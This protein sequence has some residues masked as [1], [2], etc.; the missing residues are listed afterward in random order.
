MA[1][2][3]EPIYSGGVAQLSYL[4]G[5]DSEGVGAVIDPRPDCEV[6][7]QLARAKGMAI[8]GIFETHIHAD[9][10]SGAR[11][12]AKRLGGAVPVR[13]SGEGGAAYGFGVVKLADGD[14]FHFGEMRLQAAGGKDGRG[15]VRC[16]ARCGRVRTGRR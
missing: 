14:T 9:V 5:D 15:R 13:A 2:I 16:R 12:L 10:M 4:V 8:R 3:V 1:L 7:L 6:Y 11:E